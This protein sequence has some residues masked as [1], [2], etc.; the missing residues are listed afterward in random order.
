MRWKWKIG[1]VL[2]LAV[3]VLILYWA[4]SVMGASRETLAYVA[5]ALGAILLGVIALR[6]ILLG[7]IGLWLA[8]TVG[9]A[10]YLLSYVP[11]TVAL[12]LGAILSSIA[13]AVG[14]PYSTRV[15]RFV[16]RRR[17]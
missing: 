6:P 3:E 2:I 12:T 1:L 17:Y 8:G 15:A 4:G 11:P 14:W 9:S 16:L 7:L 10:W 5:G 13:S